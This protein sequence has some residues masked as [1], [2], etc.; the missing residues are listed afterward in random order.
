VRA[1]SRWEQERR[2]ELDG[3]DG[4]FDH[5]QKKEKGTAGAEMAPVCFGFEGASLIW[6]KMEQK[7]NI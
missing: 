4:D 2:E 3:T 5:F 1:R 7:K 6:R